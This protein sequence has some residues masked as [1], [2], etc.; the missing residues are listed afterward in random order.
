MF[1]FILSFFLAISMANIDMPEIEPIDNIPV[2][3]YH[4][5]GDPEGPWT[6]L[7]V[8]EENLIKQ[9]DYLLEA[10]YKTVTMTDL[11]KNRVGKKILAE[12][13]IVLSFDDGYASMYNF[14]FPALKERDMLGVFYLYPDKFGGWNSLSP[15]QIKEMAQ[16]GMEI[17]SHSKSHADMTKISR[18]NLFYELEESKKILEEISG[19]SIRSFC[20]PSGRYN[21]Q[22]IEQIKN[23]GYGSAVTTNYGKYQLAES[24]YTIKR[25]RINYTDSLDGFI[26]KIS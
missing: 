24:I 21:D 4:E 16:A 20:Y 15:E 1:N 22:V 25:V 2:L 8:S 14:V 7:Y 6:N 13:S 3:M 18:E 9:L 11:E 10:G 19:K 17:G 23:A 5:I 26:K 12:K